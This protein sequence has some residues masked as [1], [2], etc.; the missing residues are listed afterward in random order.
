LDAALGASKFEQRRLEHPALSPMRQGLGT[1]LEMLFEA[2]QPVEEDNRGA[3]TNSIIPD[4]RIA[5]HSLG[6]L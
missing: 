1:R 2:Q 3:R 5:Y 6:D 4:K